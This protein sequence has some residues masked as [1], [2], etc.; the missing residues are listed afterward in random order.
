MTG[1]RPRLSRAALRAVRPEYLDWLPGPDT[2]VGIVHLGI[3][4]FHRAHQ[5]V[6]TQLAMAAEPGDWAICGISQRHGAVGDALRPQDC[7]Y[8]VAERGAD[9]DR[10]RVVGSVREVLLAP[11]QPEHVTDRLSHPDTRVVSITVTEAGYHDELIGQ[12][13]RGLAARRDRAGDAGLTVLSCDN[14]PD[15]GPLVARLVRGFCA[16]LPDGDGLAAWIDRNVTFPSTVVDQIVPAATDADRRDVADRLGLTDLG[17][18]VAEPHR[19][20]VIEDRFAGPHPAWEKVGVRLVAD[21]APHQAAKLRLVNGTH[22]ALAYLGLLAGCRTT[23]E[24]T[25]REEFA[26]FAR[27][28]IQRETGASLSRFGMTVTETDVEHLLG[29]L[30]NRRITH[31]LSQIA[32]QGPRKLPHR[33]LEPAAELLV[34]GAEPRLICVALAGWLTHLRRA[35][36]G[37]DEQSARLRRIMAGADGADRIVAAVLDAWP[38]AP[39]A[40][41]ASAAFRAMLADA[42]DKLARDGAATTVRRYAR[43]R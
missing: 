32:A 43:P 22:S 20:W 42:L 24:V 6:F 19:Q 12:L 5:A 41:R 31:R 8:T 37:P 15:N 14:L 38:G 9:E 34:S 28:L 21:I 2:G 16:R 30:G 25:A 4:A 35:A 29:R 33:L 18:V 11:R 39:A 40:L 13:V 26:G 3:G 36:P 1:G 27:A 23:A 7:L 17:A 10:I